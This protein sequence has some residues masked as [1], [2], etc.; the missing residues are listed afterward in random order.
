MSSLSHPNIAA[1]HDWGE[2]QIGKR[3][4]VVR[5]RRVPV[6]RQPARPVR[7]R[8]LPRPV[9]GA[10]GRPG[11]V[12][13]ARLRPPQ[14]PRPHR[15][16]AGQAGVRRRPPAA[17]RRLRPGPD[18]RRADDWTE[19]S[20]VATHVARYSSPEQALAQ[21][22]DG[23]TD[24]YSLALILVEAVTGTVPFAAR[25]TVAT[26]SAR[27]GRLMPVSADLG[28]LAVGARAGRAPGAGRPLDGVRVRPGLVRAA[29]KLPRPTPIPI[30]RRRR[31]SRTTRARCAGPNDPTGGIARPPDGRA[32]RR[33]SCRPSTTGRAATGDRRRP[34]VDAGRRPPSRAGAAVADAP[35]ARGRGA[36]RRRR[37]ADGRRGRRAA[38]GSSRARS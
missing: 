31:R 24:V 16:D 21:P 37:R 15:A 2:E 4:T 6:R 9:A 20:T 30:A 14:G 1:V 34:T 19:P 33:R 23:K 36:G 22:I 17:H 35:P 28:P 26:L 38:A 10:G 3:T 5:R 27:I 8:S 13:G 7:P 32:R 12:P 11:G 25:S 18:A 29:E